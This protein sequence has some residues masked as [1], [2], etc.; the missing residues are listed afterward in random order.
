MGR[1]P[2]A[3]IGEQLQSYRATLAEAQAQGDQAIARKI[4]QQIK[5][6]EDFQQRHPEAKEAPSPFEVFCELNPS[7]VNCRVYYD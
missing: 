4:E 6:L 2:M 1:H 3:S 5:D 7:D